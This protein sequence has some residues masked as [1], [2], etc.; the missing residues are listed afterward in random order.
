NDLNHLLKIANKKK[1][2]GK[3]VRASGIADG[4]VKA[5]EIVDKIENIVLK[6]FIELSY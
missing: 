4:I 3:S 5:N 6:I 2:A 1:K